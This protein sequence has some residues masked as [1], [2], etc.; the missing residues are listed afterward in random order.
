MLPASFQCLGMITRSVRDHEQVLKRYRGFTASRL[1]RHFGLEAGVSS[2]ALAERVARDRPVAPDL[3]E[4]LTEPAGQA[5]HTSGSR[6]GTR[7]T[8]QPGVRMT[9]AQLGAAARQLDQ[10]VREV[11]R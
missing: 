4:R 3:L 8:A 11:T 5:A 7:T 9:A 6:R 1:K 10:L 2:R